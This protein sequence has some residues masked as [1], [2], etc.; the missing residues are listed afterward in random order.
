MVKVAKGLGLSR[1]SIEKLSIDWSMNKKN[2]KLISKVYKRML[3]QIEKDPMQNWFEININDYSLKEMKIIKR[4]FCDWSGFG[5][6]KTMPRDDLI[7]VSYKYD[8]VVSIS[9]SETSYTEKPITKFYITW[10]VED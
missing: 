5:F 4:Y 1:F 8:T 7:E 2:E 3:K 6:S 10:F 9:S